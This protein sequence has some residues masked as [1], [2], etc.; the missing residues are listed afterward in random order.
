MPAGRGEAPTRQ[1]NGCLMSD[2]HYPAVPCALS[3]LALV[4]R[5][6]LMLHCMSP[7]VAQSGEGLCNVMS[8]AAGGS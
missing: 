2:R 4:C 7:E 6:D 3:E 5:R 1:S 8:A